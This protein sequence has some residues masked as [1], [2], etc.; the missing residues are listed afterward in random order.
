MAN[1]QAI[2]G[3]NLTHG[4]QAH[5]AGGKW[6]IEQWVEGQWVRATWVDSPVLTMF[7]DDMAGDQMMLFVRSSAGYQPIAGSEQHAP[8]PGD[9]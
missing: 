5:R 6:R 8:P 4:W 7:F 2:A 3:L 1:P 9:P